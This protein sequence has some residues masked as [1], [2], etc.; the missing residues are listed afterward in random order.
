MATNVVPSQ[1]AITALQ[2]RIMPTTF[3]IAA[4]AAINTTVAGT[5]YPYGQD[6]STTATSFQV[7]A[8]SSYQLVDAFIS[9]NAA[10]D[11]QLIFYLNGV[12]QGEN[13]ILSTM[14]AQNNA[15]VRLTQP[16]ILKAGDVFQVSINT[17]AANGTL[18]QT[19]TLYLHFLQV[20]A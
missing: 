16:L 18:A 10:I 4:S 11:A 9:G 20:P 17:S 3:A 5:I 15:R 2:D 8:G 19:D 12:K 14:N 1:V 7:P 13:F 6:V